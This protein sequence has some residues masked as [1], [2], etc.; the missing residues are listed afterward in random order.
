MLCIDSMLAL[1]VL[2]ITIRVSLLGSREILMR[3][4][5]AVVLR[6]VGI[7]YTLSLSLGAAGRLTRLGV[8]STRMMR[9]R[10]RLWV[11][12]LSNVW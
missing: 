2:I 5:L 10:L 3:L 7:S 8:L 1:S 9:R 12:L 6:L 4:L 11:V